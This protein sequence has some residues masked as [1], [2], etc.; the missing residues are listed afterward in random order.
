MDRNMARRGEWTETENGMTYTSRPVQQSS[1]SVGYTYSRQSTICQNT[2]I[3]IGHFSIL[4]LLF[5]ARQTKRNIPRLYSSATN[6]NLR[7][8]STWET[9]SFNPGIMFNVFFRSL[10]CFHNTADALTVLIIYVWLAVRQT[11]VFKII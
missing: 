7:G 3:E 10:W 6:P 5:G 1:L 8:H 11:C 9:T 4:C 2:K